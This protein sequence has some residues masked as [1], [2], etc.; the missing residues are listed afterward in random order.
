MRKNTSRTHN[1]R[2]HEPRASPLN[3][4]QP[5]DRNPSYS[6]AT[7]AHPDDEGVEIVAPSDHDE[8]IVAGQDAVLLEPIPGDQ[9]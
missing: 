6:A 4:T 1:C 2:V 7:R 3:Q 8:I 5:Q 9:R